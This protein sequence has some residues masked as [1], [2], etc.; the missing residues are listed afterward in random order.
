MA[1]ELFN[2]ELKV[3]HLLKADPFGQRIT[4]HSKKTEISKDIVENTEDF[5]N[6]IYVDAH[7]NLIVND[8]PYSF[9]LN[10]EPIRPFA[11][12]TNTSGQK[13]DLGKY[14]EEHIYMWSSDTSRVKFRIKKSRLNSVFDHFGKDITFTKDDGD[15]VEISARVTEAAMAQFAKNY[16]PHV[17]VLEPASLVEQIKEDARKTLE[18]YGEGVR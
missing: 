13:L 7:G 16:A 12:L 4:V 10:D 5:F 9:I 8:N 6:H 17:V 2:N 1:T 3:K 14:M 15:E 11:D 18:A